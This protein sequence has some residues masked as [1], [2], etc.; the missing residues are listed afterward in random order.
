MELLRLFGLVG[1]LVLLLRWLSL[2]LSFLKSGQRPVV[3]TDLSSVN[4]LGVAPSICNIVVDLVLHV[5]LSDWERLILMLVLV[6]R[7]S[8]LIFSLV[9]F[10]GLLLMVHMG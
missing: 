1:L 4:R 5:L 9:H 7:V 3:I 2:R 6:A 10:E 8:I